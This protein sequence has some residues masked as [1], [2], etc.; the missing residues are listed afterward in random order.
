MGPLSADDGYCQNCDWNVDDRLCGNSMPCCGQANTASKINY[1][2][3]F[4]YPATIMH[5]HSLLIRVGLF[6]SSRKGD[7]G[8]ST[9][10][11]SVLAICFE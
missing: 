10:V 9:S 4:F 1:Q 11:F 5:S 2:R 3:F 6:R 8:F 7:V